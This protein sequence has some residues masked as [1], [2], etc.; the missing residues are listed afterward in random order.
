MVAI[1]S[2][3]PLVGCGSSASDV[4]VVTA[5]GNDPATIGYEELKAAISD[6]R[7]SSQELPTEVEMSLDQLDVHIR[8]AENA[9]ADTADAT[10]AQVKDDIAAITDQLDSSEAVGVDIKAGW[11]TVTAELAKIG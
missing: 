2:M 9:T 1:A 7:A 6:Y 8:D 11:T 4:S 3:V 5:S 10:Y